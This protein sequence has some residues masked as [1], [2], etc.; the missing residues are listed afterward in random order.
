MSSKSEK[1]ISQKIEELRQMAAWFESDDFDI[2]QAIERYQAA[3]KLAG[4]IEKDL[5]GLR[6]KVTILKEKFA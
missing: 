3:E 4:E 2:E 5:D 6:N 1:T